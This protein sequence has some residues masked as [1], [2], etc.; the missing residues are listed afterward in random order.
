VLILWHGR[1]I[2]RCVTLLDTVNCRCDRTLYQT[3]QYTQLYYNYSH[4]L[5]SADIGCVYSRVT[6]NSLLSLTLGFIM[7]IPTTGNGKNGYRFLCAS[8]IM[9]ITTITHTKLNPKSANLTI[10]SMWQTL[11][12]LMKHTTHWQHHHSEH[13]SYFLNIGGCCIAHTCRVEAL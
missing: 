10:T 7:D 9:G 5:M 8:F 13:Y 3:E 12:Y 1:I 11:L 4:C 6:C 2:R